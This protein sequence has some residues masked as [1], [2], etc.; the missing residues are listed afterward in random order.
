[1]TIIPAIDIID[2]RCVRLTQGDYSACKVYGDDPVEIA[3][4]YDRAGFTR[5][6]V[7]DLDGARAGRSVNLAVLQRICRETTLAV[8]FGGGIHT[9]GDIEQVFAA[10][11]AMACVGSLAVTDVP[12]V[13]GWLQ[14]YGGDRIILGADVKD[15]R[16]CIHGWKTV[17]DTT[18]YQLAEQY[19]PFLKYLMCTDIACDG[20]LGGPSTGLYR[21]ILKRLPQVHLIASGGVSS[22]DDLDQLQRLGVPSVI[23]GKAIYEGRIALDVLARYQTR[24]EASGEVSCKN[25]K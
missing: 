18:V 15:E 6:H 16:V 19:A 23:V 9:D 3:R 4:G 12:R 10:G 11:A 13:R 5:L 17:T 2:G 24:A 21:E 1:M 20:M 8:D 14:R 7:V 22:T 25:G